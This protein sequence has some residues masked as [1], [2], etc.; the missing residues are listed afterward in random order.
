MTLHEALRLYDEGELTACT[1]LLRS[2]LSAHPSHPG[3]L[4]LM[5]VAEAR[6]GHWREAEPWLRRA[7]Q[8]DPG[9]AEALSNLG[10]VLRHLR[11]FEQAEACCRRSLEQKPELLDARI[12]LAALLLD[13]GRP[14]EALALL[15][16]LVRTHFSHP[17]IW[18]NLGQALRDLGRLEEAIPLLRQAVALA[19]QDGNLHWNLAVA[20]LTAGDLLAGWGEFAW[21]WRR[22]GLCAPRLPSPAWRGEALRGRRLLLVAEQGR[23]DT[24]QFLRYAP[25]IS[26]GPVFLHCQ[27]ELVPLLRGAPG[28]ADVVGFEAPAPETDFSCLLL[29][30]PGL[31]ATDLTSIPPPLTLRPDPLRQAAWQARLQALEPPSCPQRRR[32]I[33]VVWAGT[34]THANDQNRSLPF[35][36]LAPLLELPEISWFSFQL[37]PRAVDLAGNKQIIDLAPELKDFA[38]SAAALGEMELLISVDTAMIHLAGTLNHPSFLLLPH[39]PDWRWLLR[40]DDSPWYPSLVLCRQPRPRDWEAVIQTVLQKLKGSKG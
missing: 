16:P 2:F 35:T 40:R 3:G 18:A 29:D 10:G 9:G 14:D 13:T 32:R 26:D 28:L 25:L 5:G 19:P 12:N 31:F 23:G 11:R 1:R 20:L 37:G 36:S 24:I 8:A 30:L 22:P 34:P 4:H 39:A 33:G 6:Q 38:D 21:R 27:S 15:H 7:V 17:T